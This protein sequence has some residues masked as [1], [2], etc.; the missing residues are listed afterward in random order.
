M[1]CSS[2]LKIFANSRPSAS[3]FKSFSQSLEHFFFLTVGQNNFV[4]KIPLNG[5]MFVWM[6]SSID[7]PQIN[8]S[9]Y[10]KFDF[11]LYL[12]KKRGPETA[13]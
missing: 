2:G 10:N 13:A 8:P 3:N 6:E 9:K 4:N 7:K 5:K 11:I 12:T 1:N